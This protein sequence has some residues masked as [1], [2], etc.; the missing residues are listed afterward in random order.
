MATLFIFAE[1]IEL[2][3]MLKNQVSEHRLSDSGFNIPMLQNIIPQYKSMHTFNL[4]IRVA[5]VFQNVPV[6]CLVLPRSSLAK[7]PFRMANT[8]G[9]IDAGYRGEV[10][11]M[12]DVLDSHDEITIN[13]GTRY[14]QVCQHNFLP[15]DQII[16]VDSLEALPRPPDNRGEGGFG[17]TGH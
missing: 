6:P 2:Q 4:G 14:F 12:V 3:T 11:A 10:K 17:S 15:W 9:L 1:N 13:N 7:T 8:L 16:I 5:A